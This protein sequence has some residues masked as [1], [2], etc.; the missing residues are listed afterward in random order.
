VLSTLTGLKIEKRKKKKNEDHAKDRGQVFRIK[1]R[2]G[3]SGKFS[4]GWGYWPLYLKKK[5]D[6]RRESRP[7]Y[8]REKKRGWS[9]GERR[10]NLQKLVDKKSL[11]NRSYRRKTLTVYGWAGKIS[12]E[13]GS[14]QTGKRRLQR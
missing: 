12:H 4:F 1:R 2:S 14:S 3:S 9:R 7:A 6:G 10:I 11:P 13:R 8:T 5:K